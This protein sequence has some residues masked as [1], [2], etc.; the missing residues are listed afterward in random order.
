MPDEKP[1]EKTKVLAAEVPEW[2]H[3]EA[4]MKAL[5]E[6]RNLSDVLRELVEAWL[7][8]QGGAQPK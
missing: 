2:L 5:K 8:S 4:R 1:K 3:H 6:R 7:K